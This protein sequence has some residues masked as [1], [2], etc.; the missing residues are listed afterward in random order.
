MVSIV[1]IMIRKIIV[2]HIVVVIKS[3]ETSR[4]I[5]LM[6]STT[7][8][9]SRTRKSLGQE[10]EECQ[11]ESKEREQCWE[12]EELRALIYLLVSL[13]FSE[14]CSLFTIF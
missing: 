2:I 5:R 6:Q 7:E 12:K 3:I 4:E 9:R 1:T 11:V 10:V 13:V 14:A 8:T